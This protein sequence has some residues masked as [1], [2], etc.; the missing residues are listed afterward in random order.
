MQTQPKRNLA[1]IA[2][3]ASVMLPSAF[4]ASECVAASIGDVF[5]IP[6]ENHDFTQPSSYTTQQQIQGNTAAP[7]INSLITPGNPNAADVSYATNYT[8]TGTGVHPSEPNY[9]WSEAGTNYNPSTSTTI[10]SDSDPS[11]ANKNIFTAVPHLTGLMNSAGVSWKNYQEDYQISGSGAG[12]TA[13]GTLPNG[14]TNPYNGSTLYSYAPKH[15]PMTFF[16]D[17]ATQNLNPISQLATDLNNNT[18]GRYNWIT[19][20]LYND[21]HTALSSGF[22]YHGTHYTGDQAAVAQ[23]DNFLSIL[24]PQIEASNAFKLNG[25]IIIWDDETEGGD[26][27]NYT[28]PEIVISPLARGNAYASSVALNHSSDTKTMQEIFQLGAT[29]LN[30]A[31]PSSEYSPAGGPGTYN[32]VSASNDL[33]DLF[34][35]GTIPGGTPEPSSAAIIAV[36]GMVALRRRRAR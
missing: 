3:I 15:D 28:I 9:I 8:N 18:V 25:T 24:I 30:N 20:D 29:Y 31:I 13:S 22:T 36:V 6:L 32:S 34:Q 7:F 11:A 35:S 16:S 1:K 27:T 19:P 26:T 33:S 10:T 12:V 17:T 2:V 21:M 4:A 5:V 23:G 14:G